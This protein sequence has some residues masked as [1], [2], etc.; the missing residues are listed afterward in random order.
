MKAYT[1]TEDQLENLGLLQASSTFVFSLFGAVITFFIGVR[2][3]I[4]FAPLPLTPDQSFWNGLSWGALVFA[5]FLLVAG[6]ALI[7]R[8]RT[9]ISKIKRDTVHD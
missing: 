3:N 2:Q 8:G 4:A 5:I 9:T 1:V 6:V 7:I